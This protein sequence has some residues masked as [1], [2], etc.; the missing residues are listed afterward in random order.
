[1]TRLKP[2]TYARLCDQLKSDYFATNTIRFLK[3]FKL[4]IGILVFYCNQS[5]PFSLGICL[6]HPSTQLL[7]CYADTPI[8]RSTEKLQSMSLRK[9][10]QKIIL[11][12]L[13]ADQKC[14]IDF[15]VIDL[16]RALKKTRVLSKVRENPILTPKRHSTWES[17]SVFNPGVLL[18]DDQVHF[19][20]RA[21]GDQGQSVFGYAKSE[22]GVHIAQRFKQAV[23]PIQPQ[24]YPKTK[25]RIQY[26]SGGSCY[27]TE[28]PRLVNINN[29][30]YMTYTAFDGCHAPGI[31]LTSISVQ[32]F[33]QQNWQWSSPIRLSPVDEIH[34]NW[35]IFPELIQN[36]YAILHSISP[37]IRIDYFPSLAF[38][39]APNIKS[40]Y[41][42]SARAMHWDS[43]IRGVGPIPLSIEEGWLILYHAMDHR[44]PGRY[45]LGAMILAKHDPTQI[46]FRS[47]VP[48]LEP[49]HSYENEG[50]KSGVIYCC[51]AV[52]KDERLL[53]YYGGADKVICLAH[54]PVKDVVELIKQGTV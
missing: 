13:I 22:D 54:A 30:I 28:D 4:D 45:K 5:T 14:H 51:G 37:E 42:P 29:V 17:H 18:L 46:L 47:H 34:K 31:H 11:Q 1:M 19:I 48:L 27:G 9:A 3:T 7:Q 53:V 39:R 8:W 40:H 36:Q 24:Y 10:R 25:K 52:I 44:D 49:D 21:I 32:N 2:S 43:W 23:Y 41:T 15:H 50:H 26:G 6:L 12:F 16:V 20:Y 38:K 35:V 33:L